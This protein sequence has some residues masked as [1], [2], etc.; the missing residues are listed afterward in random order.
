M[1]GIAAHR[2]TPSMRLIC[3]VL[4]FERNT[5][6]RDL[7]CPMC[8]A[9][10]SPTRQAAVALWSEGPAA[11]AVMDFAP[12]TR[13]GIPHNGVIA[14]AAD[15]RLDNRNEL[16]NALD[17]PAASD[18]WLTL[19]TFEK[20]GLDAPQHLLGDFALAWFDRNHRSLTLAR[21]IFGI[22]PIAYHHRPGQHVVF[23][24]FPRGL[25]PSGLVAQAIN[26]L[27][28]ARQIQFRFPPEDTLFRDVHMLAPAHTVTFSRHGERTHR[29][30]QASLK[31]NRH[32]TPES[33]AIELRSL[34]DTAVYS[35]IPADGTIAAHLSGGIDSSTICAFASR[36][37]Q[38]EHSQR[39]LHGFSFW[40]EER[41]ELNLEYERPFVESLLAHDPSIRCHPIPAEPPGLWSGSETHPDRL[42]SLSDLDPE[43]AVCKQAA[44]LG[45]DTILSGWGGDEGITFNGRGVMAQ[46]LITLRWN[47]LFHE[48]NAL[49]TTR[50][51]SKTNVLAGEVLPFILPNSVRHLRHHLKHGRRPP[52]EQWRDL[53]QPSVAS[54]IA[55]EKQPPTA[56]PGPFASANQLAL[57]RGDHIPWRVTNWAT[58]GAHYGVAFAFPMLDR[59]VVDFALSL[60]A[61]WHLRDGFKRRPI[62]DATDG[63]LPDLIRWRHTKIVPYPQT[64]VEITEH[65]DS[66]IDRVRQLNAMP[67]V[68]AI[69]Q[70][71]PLMA[72]AETIP[73]P[74]QA[75]T[76]HR[77]ISTQTLL[78][79]CNVIACCNF[80]DASA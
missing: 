80:L 32:K 7:L 60:S 38:A 78:T 18:S 9:M 57:I 49:H 47:Y 36:A 14:L 44:A 46:A 12:N 52:Q 23:A 5:L 79:L 25:F 67:A 39:P 54:A 68:N 70:P 62:R 58:A 51:W 72:L 19:G 21:D 76:T 31:P 24:S 3:G 45:A 55:Q 4:S 64:L 1:Y 50:G 26:P 65:R 61:Q 20:W 53:F 75:V 29:Y 17:M 30:W 16:R 41:P 42:M 6:G 28:I 22:R 35:R 10:Q 56:S 48:M 13:P 15:I 43:N 34:V 77:H 11:L 71:E 37:L 66:I 8:D 2:T 40:P 33:A 59:R 73:T 74:A 69:F 63:I 27:A